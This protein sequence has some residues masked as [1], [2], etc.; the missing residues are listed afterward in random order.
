MGW[1]KP[2]H[3]PLPP[4]R[5]LLLLGLRRGQARQRECVGL[6]HVASPTQLRLL[7]TLLDRGLDAFVEG[8]LGRGEIRVLDRRATL[9]GDGLPVR[10]TMNDVRLH[11]T[12][13]TD[14]GTEGKAVLP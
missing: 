4:L 5:L 3:F 6:G 12:V 11:G 8:N 7:P 1:P 13:L 14:V 9:R 2:P 10:G